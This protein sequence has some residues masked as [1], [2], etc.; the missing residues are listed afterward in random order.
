M[1][2]TS[3]TS[4]SI[5]AN[6]LYVKSLIAEYI[7]LDS[8]AIY[9]QASYIL[10]AMLLVFLVIFWVYYQ[11][12]QVRKTDQ[13]RVED[14]LALAEADK[15]EAQKSAQA[16]LSFLA[17]MS[18]EIRTP[19]NG[20]FGMAEALSFTELDKEQ[21]DLLDT[22]KGSA[23][24]LLAL[25]NDVLD[26][27]KMDA[28]KMTL[29]Q[30]PVHLSTLSNNIVSTFSH[31]DGN[32]HLNFITK[33]DKDLNDSYLTDPTRITQILNNLISNAVKF[34]HDGH[35]KI[36]IDLME[37]NH[38][39]DNAYDTIRLSVE[40]TGIGIPK[41]KQALL[42]TPFVQADND[43]TRKYGGTGLGLSICQ[44]I[45]HAMGGDIKLKS[46]LGKGSLF[47]FYLTVKHAEPVVVEEEATNDRRKRPRT[48]QD[49]TEH[50]FDGLR[51]LI[52]EDN[53]IN[54][55]VICAQLSRLNIIADVA[56]DGAEALM[57]H[58]KIPYDIIIS[59]CHMPV[60]DGFELA[61][62][63]KSRQHT[64]PLWVIAITA[65]ALNGSSDKCLAA[66]FDDYMAKPCPQ[67]VITDR[68]NNAYREIMTMQKYEGKAPPTAEIQSMNHLEQYSL[69]DLNALL[70]INDQDAIL[71]ANIAE[72]FIHTWKQDKVS[73]QSTVD[74][75]NFDAIHALTH[76]LRGSVK[77]LCQVN[78]E[79]TAKK[80]QLLAQNQE[81]Q[82]VQQT[83]ILL[84]EQFDALVKE[85]EHWLANNPGHTF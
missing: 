53:L 67:I 70:E 24:N 55:K 19:M 25:L 22:L 16:K 66:G 46:T 28:G 52:A 62:Q 84:V 6:V 7:N 17:R 41:E 63:L 64:K 31:H 13:T 14:A 37:R 50:R 44:E 79:K 71:S 69:F 21:T 8:P 30:V 45:V 48:V 81:L 38:S 15:L 18:H 10:F 47:Y 58:D 59:D 57:M 74:D 5:E 1:N 27:S 43:V 83:S 80:L 3:F 68:L 20:V 35:I 36:A 78:I 51:V 23:H 33:I 42:F 65:D 72:L 82:G 77:Y 32:K 85:I 4:F 39:E 11:K 26:F 29:E 56:H 2:F 73:L 34:T 40:D 9:E 12:T 76:K 75:K 54:I 61:K 60:M 49:S